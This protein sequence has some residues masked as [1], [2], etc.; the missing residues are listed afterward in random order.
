MA[1]HIN[2]LESINPQNGRREN[3]DI[4]VLNPVWDGDDI[5]GDKI[6]FVY[7]G[8]EFQITGKDARICLKGLSPEIVEIPDDSEFLSLEYLDNE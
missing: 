2:N 7:F 8:N 5:I 1:R 4:Y 3:V 6:V